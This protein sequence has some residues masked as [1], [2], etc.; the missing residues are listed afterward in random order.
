MPSPRLPLFG[1]PSGRLA[2]FETSV[3]RP[4]AP[5]GETLLSLVTAREA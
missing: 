3:L 5:L 1:T 2:A 4:G